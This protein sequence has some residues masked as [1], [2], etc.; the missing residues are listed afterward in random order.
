LK[1][2][3]QKR[4]RGAF[5]IRSQYVGYLRGKLECIDTN[6]FQIGKEKEGKEEVGEF[7]E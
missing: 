6:M 7:V 5:N 2:S 3:V 4:P 1:F